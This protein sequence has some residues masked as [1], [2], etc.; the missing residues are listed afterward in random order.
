MGGFAFALLM[1]LIAWAV[2]HAA[3]VALAVRLL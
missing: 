3:E 2:F 1:V